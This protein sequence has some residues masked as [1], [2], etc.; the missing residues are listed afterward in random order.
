MKNVEKEESKAV[1]PT[2]P[3]VD[4]VGSSINDVSELYRTLFEY[5]KLR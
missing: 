4:W 2:T 1:A 3:E 5:L